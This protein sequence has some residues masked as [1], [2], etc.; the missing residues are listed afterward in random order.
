MKN[1]KFWLESVSKG[2]LSTHIFLTLRNQTCSHAKLSVKWNSNFAN[3]FQIL[4]IVFLIKYFRKIQKEGI[5]PRPNKSPNI[6][7]QDAAMK[8]MVHRYP[9]YDLKKPHNSCHYP[10][11]GLQ[12]CTDGNIVF[13]CDSYKNSLVIILY[14]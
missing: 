10:H 3:F 4:K 1:N 7:Y 9:D 6:Q 8:R 5:W 2:R 13:R 12:K 14:V 11:H